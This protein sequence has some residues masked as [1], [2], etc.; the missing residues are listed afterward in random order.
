MGLETLAGVALLAGGA[1][2]GSELTK[3]DEGKSAEDLKGDASKAAR[4]KSI[5]RA[6][7]RDRNKTVFTS[8][9]GVAGLKQ[10]LGE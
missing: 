8:P 9:S 1:Y 6:R 10:K 3:K 4:E 2:A 7:A 5:K